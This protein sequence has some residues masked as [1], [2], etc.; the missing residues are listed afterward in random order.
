MQRTFASGVTCKSARVAKLEQRFDNVRI[1]AQNCLVERKFFATV[2][3][4]L[5]GV[6]NNIQYAEIFVACCFEQINQ[7][8][9][10]FNQNVDIVVMVL[11]QR[12]D[13]LDVGMLSRNMQRRGHYIV[14]RA[15][16]LLIFFALSVVEQRVHAHVN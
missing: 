2:Y 11:N 6:E 8:V 10:L 3:A 16:Q 12:F 15:P 13:R 9:F 4:G 5:L 1:A 7:E 14:D